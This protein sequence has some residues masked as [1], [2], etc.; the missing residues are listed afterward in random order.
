MSDKMD[1]MTF[2]A[3]IPTATG[4]PQVVV[5]RLSNDDTYDIARSLED[6]IV[7]RCAEYDVLKAKAEL[8]GDL[9]DCI[10]N[11]INDCTHF[12]SVSSLLDE[13]RALRRHISK[14]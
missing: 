13:A 10:D 3:R 2:V 7:E 5:C 11:L 4:C 6:A 1:V 14:S 9:I 12:E 8:F